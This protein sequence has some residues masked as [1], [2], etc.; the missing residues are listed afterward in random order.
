MLVDFIS[1]IYQ[2]LSG[3]IQLVKRVNTITCYPLWLQS[4][5]IAV[6]SYTR[7]LRITLKTKKGFIDEKKFKFYAVKAFEVISKATMEIPNK[8]KC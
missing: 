1:C 7:T 4:I 2:L 8:S 6:I 5:N 3:E